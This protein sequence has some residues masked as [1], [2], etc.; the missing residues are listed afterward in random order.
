MMATIS[1]SAV[2]NYIDIACKN[3][4]QVSLFQY[5][6][7]KEEETGNIFQENE[8]DEP[9]IN[10]NFVWYL[11]IK[12]ADKFYQIYNRYPGE[13]N[14]DKFNDDVEIFNEAVQTYLNDNSRINILPNG[15]NMEDIK[16][17]YIHEF[18]RNSNTQIPHLVSIIGSMASQEIIKM[19]TYKFKTVNNT[20]IYDGIHNTISTFTL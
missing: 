6:T 5:N 11:L 10:R 7:L 20:I 16:R 8:L 1:D 3:W 14:H 13:T 12:A 15:F 17:E 9:H 18:C 4:P 2:I 19:I